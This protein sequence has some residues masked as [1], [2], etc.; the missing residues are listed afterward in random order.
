MSRIIVEYFPSLLSN[1][2]KGLIEKFVSPSMISNDEETAQYEIDQCKGVCEEY[3]LTKDVIL[4]N[5]LILNDVNYIE[6][7]YEG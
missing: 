2:A 7:G 5:H 6:L 4:I 1:K 3:S